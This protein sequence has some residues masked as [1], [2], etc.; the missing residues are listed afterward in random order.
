MR[1]EPVTKN[2][3]KRQNHPPDDVLPPRFKHFPAITVRP[4]GQ[5]TRR[6]QKITTPMPLPLLPLTQGRSDASSSN[7]R[8]VQKVVMVEEVE[9]EEK[10][11]C[12][13]VNHTTCYDV[14]ETVYR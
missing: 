10:L 3:Q 6:S 11:Q 13:H 9:H 1:F 7:V 5:P 8:C 2:V 14:Y 12:S 4:K